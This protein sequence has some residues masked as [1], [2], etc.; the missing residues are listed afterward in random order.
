M[1]SPV[2]LITQGRVALQS[3][4]E[5]PQKLPGEFQTA[6]RQV[7][8]GRQDWAGTVLPRRQAFFAAGGEGKSQ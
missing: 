6:L 7:G 4:R 8:W 5:F 1:D 2:H 3:P